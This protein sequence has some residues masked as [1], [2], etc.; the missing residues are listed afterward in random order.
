[1]FIC[2]WG[3][4]AA[5][6]SLLFKGSIIPSVKRDPTSVTTSFLLSLSHG[7][8][9]EHMTEW[10]HL[11]LHLEGP[12]HCLMLCYCRLEILFKQ[13]SP[14]FHFALHPADYVANP[15][16]GLQTMAPTEALGNAGNILTRAFS[17]RQQRE[18]SVCHLQK[19]VALCSI[20]TL[21]CSPF[22][23]LWFL[24]LPTY[25]GSGMAASLSVGYCFV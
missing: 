7:W 19:I 3:L 20:S 18:G 2:F 4:S 11:A 1:M 25:I 24:I 22:W 8:L 9:C 13:G 5:S 17:L 16:P 23:V 12:S 6:W 14:H 15:S 21:L 10:L